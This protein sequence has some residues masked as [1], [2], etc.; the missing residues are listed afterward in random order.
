VLRSLVYFADA[1]DE[2]EP[3][4]LRALKW[5]EVKRSICGA[6]ERLERQ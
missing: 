6:V 4:M 2:P 1:E 5:N 3:K